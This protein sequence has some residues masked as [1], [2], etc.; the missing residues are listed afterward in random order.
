[1]AILLNVYDYTKTENGF[2]VGEGIKNTHKTDLLANGIENSGT[3]CS[4]I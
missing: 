4:L 1:M 2:F 3:T